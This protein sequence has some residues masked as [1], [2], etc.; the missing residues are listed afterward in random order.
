[1]QLFFQVMH[2]SLVIKNFTNKDIMCHGKN[3]ML[4]LIIFIIY[5]VTLKLFL[6]YG[7][8]L[9]INMVQKKNILK[10]IGLKSGLIFKWLMRK[11]FSSNP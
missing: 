6:K 9:N 4:C 5:F 10:D 11:V 8:H 3:L 2:F 7:K 1:M